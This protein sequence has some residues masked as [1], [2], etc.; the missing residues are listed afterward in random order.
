MK[1]LIIGLGSIA[2]KHILAL[3]QINTKVVIF[4][5]RSRT[6][7]SQYQ[8]ITNIYNTDE[9]ENYAFD[10]CIISSPTTFH[11]RDIEKII[12]FKI[13]LFI[14]KP[15]FSTL[16]NQPLI[17]SI[18]TNHIK[19]YVA[20]NLRF[21]DSLIY[22]KEKIIGRS[23]LIINEV[24]AYCG[25]YLPD[26]RPNTDYR[27]SY[28]A[29]EH[30]GGGVHIDLIHEI[31]YLYWLLGAPIKTN[32]LLKSNSS[33]DIS[34]IDYANFILEYPNFVSSVKLNYYRRDAKRYLEILFNDFTIYI[35]LLTN[36][37][38]KNGVQIYSS[39]QK[40]IDTYK[41]Q[42]EYFVENI[43][44][45]SFNDIIEAYEVLKICIKLTPRKN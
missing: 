13:P 17:D 34:A 31:D 21:L 41:P 5:L 16:D 22:V 37:V 6:N 8:D 1:V 3:K 38:Y 4:A 18:K 28:S 11:A 39:D 10:F 9:L 27:E 36:T 43:S 33:L 14:E 35:D 2:K 20:C 15:L 45:T 32:R 19:T 23:E 29:N 40:I 25:S 30:L 7:A 12:Q 44:K 42:L 24:N 26:W